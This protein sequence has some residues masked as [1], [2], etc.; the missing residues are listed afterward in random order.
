MTNNRTI[1]AIPMWK[2]ARQGRRFD[3]AF[4]SRVAVDMDAILRMLA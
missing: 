4:T 3:L 1:A 2:P